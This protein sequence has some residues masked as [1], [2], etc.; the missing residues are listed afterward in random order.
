[1]L[2]IPSNPADAAQTY[3]KPL[4]R[5]IELAQISPFKANPDLSVV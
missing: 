2:E 1:V 3:Q 5:S 4:D